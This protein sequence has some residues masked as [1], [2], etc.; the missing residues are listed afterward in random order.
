MAKDAQ[1]ALSSCPSTKLA[2]SGYSQ[3]AMVV[4]NALSAQGLDGS[5]VAAIVVYGDPLNG[6]SF[7]GVDS[8]KVLEICGSSDTICASGPSNVSGSHLSYSSDTQ[9]GADFI[10]KNA[11]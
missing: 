5:K 2:L 3:G 1:S 10:V 6:Q 4:H 9:Q 7:K 8:S 11:A